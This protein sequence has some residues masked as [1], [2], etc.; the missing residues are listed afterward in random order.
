LWIY[1][2]NDRFDGFRMGEIDFRKIQGDEFSKRG[3]GSLK[4]PAKLA[5]L[6]KKKNAEWAEGYFRAEGYF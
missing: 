6:S 5:M 1:L 4:F 3:Q 2:A